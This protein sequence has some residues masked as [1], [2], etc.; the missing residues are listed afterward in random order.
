M[1]A[2]LAGEQL[3]DAKLRQLA[4]FASVA[5]AC[6]NPLGHE[7]G[8]RALQV[9]RSSERVAVTGEEAIGCPKKLIVLSH[10]MSALRGELGCILQPHLAGDMLSV[11]HPIPFHSIQFGPSLSQGQAGI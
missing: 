7:C 1:S 2:D 5:E 10:L 11:L 3:E 9:L 4:S 8:H 6:V